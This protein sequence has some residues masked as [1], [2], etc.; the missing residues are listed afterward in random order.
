MGSGPI[1]LTLMVGPMVPVPVPKAVL[2]ALTGVQIT[3]TAGRA[4]GFQL[5]F[6]LTHDSP[7]HTLFLVSAGLPLKIIRVIIVV[8][9]NG[10]PEV[11]MDG[12]MRQHEV[13]PGSEPGQSTLTVSG[14]DL[15]AVMDLVEFTG[16][17]YPAMPPSARVVAILA[18]YAMFGMVPQVIPSILFEVPNPLETIP[19]HKGTDLKYIKHLAD[20]VGYVFYLDAGPAPG[21]N[22]AYWGPEIKV[23][24]PQPALNLD[25]DAHTNVESLNFRYDSQAKTLPVVYIHEKLTKVPIPIP[26]PDVNPLSPPLGAVPAVP[27]KIS[28]IDGT[29]KMTPTQAIIVGLAKA[30]QTSDVVTGTG[31]LNV[32]RYGRVLKARQLVGVRGAGLAF[33]G[34][35]Y[36]KSVTHNLKRGE[37]K[38]NFTLARNGLISTVPQVRA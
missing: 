17:P 19:R 37:Y 5:T 28:Y 33:D 14:D 35:Y 34:L 18:K 24:L 11:L 22:V 31:S 1:H 32:L 8:T 30:A 23:G 3:T 10:T 27:Q 12:V 2:D 6:K 4:S 29:A 25:M 21:M 38:Q 15:T 16:I 26:L 9:V 7:L 20:E 36:V 13:T